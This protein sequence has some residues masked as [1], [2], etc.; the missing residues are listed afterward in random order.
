MSAPLSVR[1]RAAT[2]DLH[3]RVEDRVDILRRTESRDGTAD[4]MLRMEAFYRAL[5]P[6]LARSLAESVPPDYLV[7]RVPRLRIDL[8]ALAPGWRPLPEPLL[9]SEADGLGALYVLEGASIGGQVIARHLRE[10]L[11]FRSEFFGGEGVG[12]R[13]RA[14]RTLL[15]EREDE[16]AIEA[17]KATFLA[18]EAIVATP[19]PY[20]SLPEERRNFVEAAVA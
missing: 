12:P 10:R 3:Q 20:P 16:T 8:D 2:I 17:A 11:A 6:R 7:A 18:F 9:S 5:E 4:L 19:H 1:L 15:D 13:W 14:F